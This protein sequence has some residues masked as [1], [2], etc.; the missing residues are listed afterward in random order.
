MLL[1]QEAVEMARNAMAAEEA[2]QIMTE[3]IEEEEG[4]V[5]NFDDLGPVL[6]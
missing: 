2:D 4:P 5:P 6:Y 1:P 3:E